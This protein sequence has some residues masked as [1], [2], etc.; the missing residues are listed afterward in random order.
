M[1]KQ[2]KIKL[3]IKREVLRTMQAHELRQVDGGNL[4]PVPLTPIQCP[5]PPI[6]GD[7]VRE[8]CS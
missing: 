3:R 5:P 8:C 7:S 1:R 4:V 2:H 6:T